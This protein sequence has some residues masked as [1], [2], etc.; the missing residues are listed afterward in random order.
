MGC[1][2]CKRRDQAIRP[3]YKEKL[4]TETGELKQSYFDEVVSISLRGIKL[5]EKEV[6]TR[7]HEWRLENR[8]T[9][10]A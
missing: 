2:F 9:R 4:D 1:V 10:A 3:L 6:I 7:V 5:G 8:G